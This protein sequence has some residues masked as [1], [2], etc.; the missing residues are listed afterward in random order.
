MTGFAADWLALRAPADD[1]ARDAGLVAA[2]A[3]WAGGRPIDVVDL[4]AGS[5]ATM[6]ALHAALPGARWRLID[7]DPALLALAATAGARLGLSVETRRIDLARELSAALAP[8]PALVTASAFFDLAGAA[9]IERF[10]DAA[11]GAGAAVYAALTYDGREAWSPPHP[12]D[13]AVHA[14]FLTD[15]RRDKGL[16]PALGAEAGPFLAGALSARGYRVATADTPWRLEA[17]RD[18][19]MIAA[20][21]DGCADAGDASPGWRAARRAAERAEIGHLDVLALPG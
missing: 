15:M 20:L 16:G 19:A 14:R 7:D 3:D 5:G 18:A 6:K 2:L 11:A 10:A 8:P 9:W 12:E 4:G 1:R 13:A 17:P 21:A